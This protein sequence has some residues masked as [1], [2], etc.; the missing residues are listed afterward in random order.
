MSLADE[1]HELQKCSGNI[2]S[3]Q[4]KTAYEKCSNPF[5]EKLYFRAALKDEG[6]RTVP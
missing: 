5:E 3:I 6:L 1:G 2:F 4:I